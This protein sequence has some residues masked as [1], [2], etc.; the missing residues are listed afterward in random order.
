MATMSHQQTPDD[1]AGPAHLQT[2]VQD[3]PTS[4]L[5]PAEWAGY[6]QCCTLHC[7]RPTPSPRIHDHVALRGCLQAR[8]PES[9]VHALTTKGQCRFLLLLRP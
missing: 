8:L 7:C 5:D 1:L 3:A 2:V 9:D 4:E 6:F